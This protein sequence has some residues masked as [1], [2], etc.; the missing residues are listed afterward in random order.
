M[1]RIGQWLWWMDRENPRFRR[2]VWAKLAYSVV[3]V[4]GFF[5]LL[6]FS[7]L[8]INALARFGF[9]GRTGP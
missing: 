9:M 2:N 6:L 8:A 1:N 3:W 7:R 5:L 4:V